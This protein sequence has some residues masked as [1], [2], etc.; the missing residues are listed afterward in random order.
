MKIIYKLGKKVIYFLPSYLL[1]FLS[2]TGIISCKGCDNEKFN[3]SSNT[4]LTITT[5]KEHYKGANDVQ[6]ILHIAYID[7]D[8]NQS[9][10][11]GSFKLKLT[12]THEGSTQNSTVS[13]EVLD[14][15][16]AISKK[17]TSAATE[18]LSHFFK[19]TNSDLI[20][21]G[22]ELQK[23]FTI[24][25]KGNPTKVTVRYELLDAFNNDNLLCSRTITWMPTITSEWQLMI[26]GTDMA[27]NIKT[28]D[29]GDTNIEIILSK[30]TGN[31]I[32]EDEV[33]EL[34]LHIKKITAGTANLANIENGVLKLMDPTAFTISPNKK[35]VIKRLTINPGTD[36]YA[37]FELKLQN[38]TGIDLSTNTTQ[39]VIWKSG[40]QLK[41]GARYNALTKK[42]S[43]EIVNAGKIDLVAK[44]AILKWETGDNDVTITNKRKGSIQLDKISVNGTFIILDLGQIT[45]ANNKQITALH[46]QIIWDQ[47]EKPIQVTRTLTSVPIDI[48][49]TH[50]SFDKVKNQI[51]YNIKNNCNQD[52][53]LQVQCINTK[54]NSENAAVITSLL[55]ININLKKAG[56]A[57]SETG[58]RTLQLDFKKESKADFSFQVLFDGYPIS[59][60][61]KTNA[62]ATE[63]ENSIITCIAKQVGL[64]FSPI[65]TTDD[66]PVDGIQLQGD[67]K[68]VK[69]SIILN[70]KDEDVIALTNIEKNRLRLVIDKEMYTDAELYRGTSHIVTAL[71]GNMLNLGGENILRLLRGSSNKASF[72]LKLMYDKTEEGNFIEEEVLATL[73]VSW[74]EDQFEII[75][76]HP[77]SKGKLT[78][79]RK[80]TFT[81]K[82]ITSTI[83]P[84]TNLTI[85]IQTSNKAD[86]TC[87]D[88]NG[89]LPSNTS[90]EQTLKGLLGDDKVIPHNT[91]T[92]DIKFKL[93]NQNNEK[94][95]VLTIVLK[96]DGYEVARSADIKWQKDKKEPKINIS[97][98]TLNGA[99]I[100]DNLLVGNS[101]AINNNTVKIT[102]NNEGEDI[103]IYT[104]DLYMEL[105]AHYDEDY[106]DIIE[107][108]LNGNSNEIVRMALKD[109]LDMSIDSTFIKGK[110]KDIVFQLDNTSSVHFAIVTIN[111]GMQREFKPLVKKDFVWINKDKIGEE[112][113]HPLVK[114]AEQ[115][116]MQLNILA[117]D[118]SDISFGQT[119][120]QIKQGNTIYQDADILL[121]LLE[122][123]ILYGYAGSDKRI[124]PNSGMQIVLQDNQRI[125]NKIQAIYKDAEAITKGN[126]IT[127]IKQTVDE[128]KD[129]YEEAKHILEDKVTCFVRKLVETVTNHISSADIDNQPTGEMAKQA[130]SSILKGFK[131]IF[132][133]LNK[134]AGPYYPTDKGMNHP[135]NLAMK[136]LNILFMKKSDVIAKKFRSERKSEEAANFEKE[137]NFFKQEADQYSG[138][139]FP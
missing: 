65:G 91:E 111:I 78:S 11:Y 128:V 139:C 90:V 32:T 116:K 135:F 50:L 96:K 34:Q 42:V 94:D 52:I 45:F 114:I 64:K 28:I 30:V 115:F 20:A 130:F 57:A 3:T 109:V 104:E 46:L 49:V 47:L 112:K 33:K 127:P 84:A 89:N 97:N 119:V 136:Q 51:T 17:E 36:N 99:P 41:I 55:P 79:F 9:A 67:S 101:S 4:K 26:L 71:A 60:K 68:E 131:Q 6:V 125:L 129:I 81:L 5:N 82:N 56:E 23:V 113:T 72:I 66:F 124:I 24:I 74:E 76:K 120:K 108:N 77:T 39:K 53:R 122:K 44:R 105:T 70:G 133:T 8:A 59:F 86:F 123:A 107:F 35:S 61:D 14:P 54:T 100:T 2:T 12:V 38:Q 126:G 134:K 1:I 73:P 22:E 37:A 117:G 110:S 137:V 95:A 7:K 43:V 87:L 31:T 19:A 106:E 15:S 102:L 40:A 62:I 27:T 18:E 48:T 25:P 21:S 13:Y 88:R 92:K 29:D 138:V 132:N 83:D 10:A 103:D 80:G 85:A 58:I 16:N 75:V 118:T 69:F 93:C 98:I 121:N 63:K